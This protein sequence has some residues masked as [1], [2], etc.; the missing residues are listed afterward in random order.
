M[1]SSGL[2]M[3]TNVVSL[4][5]DNIV[6]IAIPDGLPEPKETIT[7]NA[8]SELLCSK[9]DTNSFNLLAETAMPYLRLA[10]YRNQLLHLFVK[11][12]I[13]ALCLAPES[14]YGTYFSSVCCSCVCHNLITIIETV[15]KMFCAVHCALAS[16]FVLP[17]ESPTKVCWFWQ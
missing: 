9:M 15:Q 13:L 5:S 17:R 8:I 6:T 3:L 4:S 12:A 14:D 7:P 1:V 11:D 16:E 10:Y 2:K